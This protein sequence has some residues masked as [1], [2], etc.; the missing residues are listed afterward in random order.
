MGTMSADEAI[1]TVL[2]SLD[3]YPQKVH[4]CY[5]IHRDKPREP[6]NEGWIQ[7]QGLWF[8]FDGKK[9]SGDMGRGYDYPGFWDRRRIR[10]ATARWAK[11]V[12]AKL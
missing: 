7:G 2:A 1:T 4:R 9:I 11:H 12:G 10:Q 6:L 8:D 5:H 3:L